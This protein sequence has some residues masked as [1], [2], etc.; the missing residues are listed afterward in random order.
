MG[1]S[2]PKK[3]ATSFLKLP[4]E[5]KTSVL[6]NLSAAE[7]QASRRV[8][9]D[10]K[11]IVDESGNNGLIKKHIRAR[12][13]ARIAEELRPIFSLSSTLNL[14]DFVL[15]FLVKRGIWKHPSKTQLFVEMACAQWTR[16]RLSELEVPVYPQD[17]DAMAQSLF[18]V[19]ACFARV[20]KEAYHP[21]LE[22]SRI[23]GKSGSG[24][25]SPEVF[26]GMENLALP[27]AKTIDGFYSLLDNL[28]FGYT[29]Q[30]LAE[31]GLPLKRDE[32]GASFLEIVEKRLDGI[33]GVVPCA[34][35]PRLAIP[36]YLLTS[37]V[38]FD[39]NQADAYTGDVFPSVVSGICT[40][41]RIAE[42]LN[43]ES[44]QEVG[45]VFGYSLKSQWAHELFRA[46]L[47]GQVLSELQTVAI[48]EE[49]Y[50]F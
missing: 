34:P 18:L 16:D 49:L 26:A 35:S 12:A 3:H 11:D 42:I 47:G 28:P 43:T 23:T 40:A 6:S 50:L 17:V 37:V 41:A 19:A 9:K 5:L 30:S 4:A 20:Y 14:R 25:I 38:I 44:V 22:A 48:L 8:C 45:D 27:N 29:F 7:L 31:R 13:E 21:E 39:N 36:P 15:A 10:I 33:S 1:D 24:N 32:L 2:S 46:A